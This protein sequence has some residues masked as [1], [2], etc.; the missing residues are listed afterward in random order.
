MTAISES[1]PSTPLLPEASPPTSP[2]GALGTVDQLLRDPS[3][4]LDRI[5]RGEALLPT[6][7]A[8]ILTIAAGG[9]AFGA[10]VGMFR[11]GLQVA[12]AG[13]K[14]PLVTLLTAAVCAPAL[15]AINSA[16]ARGAD[17]RRDLALVLAVLARGSLVLAAEA[18]LALLAICSGVDYHHMIL[19][20]VGCCALAGLVGLGLLVKALRAERRGRGIVC[21]ALLAVF[22]LVGIQMSWVFRP[23]LVRPRTVDVPMMR[24]VE[25]DFFEAV[26][27][28]LDSARGIYSEPLSPGPAPG[29]VP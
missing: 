13:I 16:L 29:N 7:R 15:T 10:A 24:A 3:G 21:L 2:S 5:S 27:T 4:I 23:Y 11:G 9:A 8:L 20:V 12:A 18:P 6:A 28:S 19:L 1:L 22:G 25:G 17:L 14:L 26:R